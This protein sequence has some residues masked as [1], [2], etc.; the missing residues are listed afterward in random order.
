MQQDRQRLLNEMALSRELGAIKTAIER[1]ELDY[2]PVLDQV[3]AQLNVRQF[4]DQGF[5]A[6]ARWWSRQPRLV[7]K[8]WCRVPII[9]CS[10]RP[11]YEPASNRLSQTSC[12]PPP[13]RLVMRLL[14]SSNGFWRDRGFL[15]W[16]NRDRCVTSGMNT[17]VH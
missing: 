2:I 11:L 3:I 6:T 1:G 10:N 7:G 12:D 9:S 4:P 14:G 17:G 13:A 5:A 16:V 15:A 8:G